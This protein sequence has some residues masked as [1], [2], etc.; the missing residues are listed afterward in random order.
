MNPYRLP[1]FWSGALL[2]AT[3]FSVPMAH[4]EKFTIAV[5]SDTQNYV[6]A[7]YPQPRGINA[8]MQQMQYIVDT[9]AAKNTVFATQVGDLVQHGDGQFRTGSAGNY[10]YWKTEQEWIYADQAMSILTDANIPFGISAGNHDFENYSWY[11]TGPNGT[12]GPGASRPLN[13]YNPFPQYFGPDSK[14]YKDKSWYGGSFAGNNSYQTFEGGGIKFINLSLEME[15][16]IATLAWAQTVIDA[17]PGVPTIITTHEWMDPNFTGS[18]ARSNDHNSYF[19]N[20]D[21]Q[22]PDQVWDTFIRQND[23][24]F[25]VLAGHDFKAVPGMPGWSNGEVRRTDLNDYGHEVYQVVT[26]YQ[27]NTIGPDGVTPN[28]DNGGSGW[29]RFM[30]FDT[31]T[32]MIHFYTYSTLMDK[33]AGQ[34]GEATFGVS[35]DNSDFYLPFTQQLIAAAVPEPETYAL[36]LAGLGLVGAAARRRARA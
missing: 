11:P 12:A 7:S 14:H 15:P 13:G 1:A 20:T 28:A 35:A 31:E 34:N 27:G 16:T 10:T 26:D 17:N 36:M 19:A 8:F 33:Y 30:E 24:I 5:I 21:H 23:Q 4:A 6:D 32:Q 9:K 2:V 29:M 3:V 22:T 25:M 18:T